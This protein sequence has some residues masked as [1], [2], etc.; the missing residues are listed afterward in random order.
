M[1]ITIMVSVSLTVLYHSNPD[2]VQSKYSGVYVHNGVWG[3]I[4]YITIDGNKLEMT[5]FYPATYQEDKKIETPTA[6]Y[7]IKFE[8]GQIVCYQGNKVKYYFSILPD[9]SIV[10]NEGDFVYNKVKE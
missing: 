9:G 1:L 8:S 5:T 10:E 4:E 2:E 6:Q 3:N 7:D